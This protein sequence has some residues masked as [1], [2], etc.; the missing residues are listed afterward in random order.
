MDC[1]IHLE[2]FARRQR[3]LPTVGQKGTAGWLIRNAVLP[4]LIEGVPNFHL[5]LCIRKGQAC[6]MFTLLLPTLEGG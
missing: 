5:R 6:L 4:C 3:R 2:G 1:G